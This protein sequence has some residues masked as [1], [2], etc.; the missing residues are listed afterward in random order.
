MT[1]LTDNW[2]EI[3]EGAL[4]V[5]L[6]EGLNAWICP[7]TEPPT[8]NDNYIIINPKNREYQYGGSL[9]VY[10]RVAENSQGIRTR[11]AVIPNSGDITR[12][13]EDGQYFDLRA[14]TIG[15][16][17][18]QAGD[19]EAYVICSWDITGTSELIAFKN[20]EKSEIAGNLCLI[21][22][23]TALRIKNLMGKTVIVN[24]NI[25]YR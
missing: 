4:T 18:I 12:T 24:C 21:S 8:T 9:K 5:Q 3:G 20:V 22:T 17:F 13:L 11:I 2:Q 1:T 6:Q 19:N 14:G 15:N 25:N 10:G 16:G 23:G 7:G